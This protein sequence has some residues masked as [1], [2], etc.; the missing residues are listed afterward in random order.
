MYFCISVQ[1]A[2]NLEFLCRNCFHDYDTT[3]ESSL[4][5]VNT[6]AISLFSFF[7]FFM[8]MLFIC[9][10]LLKQMNLLQTTLMVLVLCLNRAK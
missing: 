3:K 4:H 6:L 2:T 10:C 8:F 1:L 9:L 7:L 5:S